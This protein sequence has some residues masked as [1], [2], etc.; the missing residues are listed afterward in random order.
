MLSKFC[1]AIRLIGTNCALFGSIILTISLPKT[2]L[3]SY[4]Y[5]QYPER[6]EAIERSIEIFFAPIYATAFIH[7]LSRLK[8]GQR[9]RYTE[10]M[11]MAFRKWQKLLVARIIAGLIVL[12]GLLLLI[13]PGIVLFVRYALLDPV[14]VLEGAG[15]T[16]ARMRSEK[17]TIGLRWQIFAVFSLFYIAFFLLVFLISLPVA[18]LSQLDTT[19]PTMRILLQF[20][21]DGATAILHTVLFLYYWEAATNERLQTEQDATLR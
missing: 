12:L 8:D 1:E 15:I 20:V 17:L 19:S 3:I 11:T 16:E 21:G 7:A 5:H 6:A 10:I 4:G 9:P 13:V 2:L 14:V 18:L